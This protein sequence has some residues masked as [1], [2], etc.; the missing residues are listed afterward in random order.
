LTAFASSLATGL[1]FIPG[2]A[3]AA[4]RRAPI[5]GTHPAWAVP[6]RRVAAQ[7]RGT[8]AIRARVYLEGR[9][10]AGL[11]AY[12]TAVSSPGNSKYRH[13]L[14][15]AQADSRFGPS[16][17]QVAALRS[18]LRSAGLRVPEIK[19]GVGGYLEVSGT[20]AQA[21]R[22]FGVSFGDYH[23]P[24]GKIDRAPE[25]AA[26][27]P[28]S[29]ASAILTVSGLDTARHTMKPV[30]TLPPAGP[31]YWVAPPTSDYYGQKIATDKPPAYGAYQPWSVTGYTPA[32][33]RGAYGVE[34][35]GMTGR[36]Q[37]VAIVGAY[38]SPTML[39]DANRYAQ[40][41]GDRPFRDGQYQQYL[42]PTW[43]D[44][45]AN[46][47]DA[48]SWYGEQT[49]D[50]ESVHGQ[51]PDARV[52]YVGAA[53]CTDQDLADALSSI[54][55]QH[56]ASV[57]TSSWGEPNDQ[58]A[59][60]DVFNRIFQAGTVEGIGFLFSSGDRG[61]ESPGEDPASDKI[62]VDFPTSS[63][64][65]TSV[66]GTSLAIGPR[67][68]YEFETSWGTM[69]DPLSASGASWTYPP[70]GPYPSSYG[71]SGGGGVSTA[72]PQP[73]YQR[74]VVPQSLATHLPDGTT[75]PKPM[76]VVPDVSALG[77]PATG[78][79]VGQTTLQPDGKTYAF[80]LSRVGGTSL[81]SPTFAGIEADAQQ[82]AGDPI[83][84]ANPAIYR[85]YGTLAFHDVTDSPFGAG[86]R[87]A[88][89]RNN[90]TDPATKQGPPLTALRTLG[91]NG[92]GAEALPAVPGY[93][94]ATG[95]GS[96]A[97]YVQ[98]FEFGARAR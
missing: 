14:S 29:V 69:L 77:D 13:Y 59:I 41:T 44:T 53:T 64:W 75:S 94:D 89:V 6:T 88:E 55:S 4:V 65:V 17:P 66:G 46:Q 83:G 39:S 74:G 1:I 76:R 54:V 21:S 26:T 70:P 3:P 18:W 47:C 34:A 61:Y 79:L 30:D 63:P 31:N 86:V 48:S 52:R 56:L 85:R 90:Y 67:N 57:V 43:A 50:V 91:V 12:A 95:V 93:D 24:D 42:S 62:Q 60:S 35:S 78:F 87:L 82:A 40:V 7:V 36:N 5:T 9:D 27:A 8:G 71:G 45:A 81:A 2:A 37:T 49:L 51:A 38:A 97:L 19:T 96:P 72:Y 23:G 32:Q 73:S 10:P 33:I 22:A 58:S 20:L 15:P 25:Q 16:R 68:N 98:S 28:S 80:S 92:E 84:F 11:T